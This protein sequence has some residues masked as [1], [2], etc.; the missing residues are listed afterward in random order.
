MNFFNLIRSFSEKNATDILRHI[1]ADNTPQ[2]E[3]YFTSFDYYKGKHSILTAE[4]IENPVIIPYP[5]FIVDQVLMYLLGKAPLTTPPLTEYPAY[6]NLSFHKVNKQ[7]LKYMSATGTAFLRYYLGTD[8]EIHFAVVPP[9]ECIPFYQDDKLIYFIRYFQ[10]EFEYFDTTGVITEKRLFIEL[11]E[12]INNDVFVSYFIEDEGKQLRRVNPYLYKPGD[13]TKI[14]YWDITTPKQLL[15][16]RN[17]PFVEFKNNDELQSDFELVQTLIDA[18]DKTGTYSIEEFLRF[19]NALLKSINAR[20][21]KEDV[22]GLKNRGLSVINVINEDG[23]IPAD[24][25]WIIKDLSKI[26]DYTR[27]LKTN[28][29][30]NILLFSRRFDPTDEQFRLSYNSIKYL[31]MLL[32]NDGSNKEEILKTGWAEVFNELTPTVNITIEYY[33]NLPQE[34]QY[35][36]DAIETAVSA[37]YPLEVAIENTPYAKDVDKIKKAQNT[38]G[39]Q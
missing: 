2:A 35:Y 24:V 4:N 29:H 22:I 16:F 10:I 18:N 7:I 37:G 15:P 20:I 36:M 39:F 8:N 32:E 1:I 25:E 28:L 5:R 11:Y 21:K 12:I 23:D 19:A 38:V 17:I 9:W 31:I 13:T 3:K 33:R 6:K 27:E 26:S 34:L 30:K 14:D